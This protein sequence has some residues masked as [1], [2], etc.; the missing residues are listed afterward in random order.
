MSIET[1]HSPRE[2]HEFFGE[3][4]CI[5]SRAQ[6]IEDGVLIDLSALY[7]AIARRYFKL[8]LAMNVEVVVLIEAHCE[9][10]RGATFENVL[11]ALLVTFLM[12]AQ[13]RLRQQEDVSRVTLNFPFRTAS[14]RARVPLVMLC[15][16]GDDAEPVLTICPPSEA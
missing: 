8:P 14:G 6:A 11:D 4:I 13:A 16:P 9:Q 2:L 7:P 3:V 15:G 12:T 10:V 5:Y 1:T